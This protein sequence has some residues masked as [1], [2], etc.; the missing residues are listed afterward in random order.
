MLTCFVEHLG[1][2]ITDI[3]H[4]YKFGLRNCQD[5]MMPTLFT[6]IISSTGETR[7]GSSFHCCLYG[8][9]GVIFAGNQNETSLSKGLKARHP[10]WRCYQV[11]GP[12]NPVFKA[13]QREQP[14]Q[15]DYVSPFYTLFP[16]FML[17]AFR[18][19]YQGIARGVWHGVHSLHKSPISHLT[20]QTSVHSGQYHSIEAAQI[21]FSRVP[22]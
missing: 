15:K 13:I 6:N 4:L 21:L 2:L 12:C 20:S 16:F 9:L 1:S 14:L 5:V 8:K 3:T 7:F 11:Y 22:L 19:S 10:S 17:R 18:K